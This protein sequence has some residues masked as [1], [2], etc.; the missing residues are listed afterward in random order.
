MNIAIF[1]GSEELARSVPEDGK[2]LIAA[3]G[4]VK[5]D[6][7]RL[8]LPETLNLSAL[9]AFGGIEIIVPRGTD[10][11]LRGFALFGG[12]EV[13]H[14]AEP[15]EVRSVLYLNAVA[16]FGAVSVVEAEA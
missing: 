1:G 7:S 6:L 15:T 13:K 14:S 9:A 12:R 3:F 8:V 4:G 16:M 10:V 5:L 11:V 2:Q